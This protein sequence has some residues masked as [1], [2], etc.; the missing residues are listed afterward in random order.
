MKSFVKIILLAILAVSLSGCT[1]VNERC[2]HGHV[3]KE[4]VVINSRHRPVRPA[5]RP[6]PKVTHHVP[7]HGYTK[8]G[9]VF[10]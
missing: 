7:R 5:H 2:H 10:P 4:V 6:S 9:H 8:P 1:I 3:C